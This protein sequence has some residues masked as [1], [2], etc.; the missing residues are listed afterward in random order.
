[1]SLHEC[2]LVELPKISDYR[3][4]LSFVEGNRHV[5]FRIERAYFLYDVPA[6]ANRAGHA[7]RN[8]R[9]LIIALSGSFTV[10][11]TD[12]VSTREFTLNRP[13][14]GLLLAPMIWRDLINFSSGSVCLVLAS[15]RYDEEDYFRSMEQFREA[16]K[17][18]SV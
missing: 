8:L 5:P 7:H 15:E 10:V 9:Q 6:G 13:Y 4:N 14:E 18:G 12:G 2:R 1:M 17:E 11:L 3:G 16:L